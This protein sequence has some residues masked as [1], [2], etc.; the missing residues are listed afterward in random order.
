LD[1]IAC[2]VRR[3]SASGILPLI[4]VGCLGEPDE[5]GRAVLFRAADEAG[6]ITGSTLSINGG[7]Y[8]IGRG[9]TRKEVA[10]S[11]RWDPVR[12][13]ARSAIVVGPLA[14]KD[15]EGWAPSCFVRLSN[16][17]VRVSKRDAAASADFGG[18]HTAA[19]LTDNPLRLATTAYRS[20]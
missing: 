11:Q 19:E 8:M 17:S 10:I 16:N 12:R 13:R 6:A 4:P 3:R 15:S 20:S 18:G 1:L 2:M 7:A 9:V 5:I 14:S